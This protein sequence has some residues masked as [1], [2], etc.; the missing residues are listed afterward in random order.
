[1]VSYR[2]MCR[3]VRNIDFPR[4]CACITDGCVGNDT[5][6]QGIS[7]C[8]SLLCIIPFFLPITVALMTV[9]EVI[10]TSEL[11]HKVFVPPPSAVTTPYDPWLMPYYFEDG[12]RRVKPYHFTYNTYCKERWRGR[13]LIDI[14]ATEFRDRPHEYYVS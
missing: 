11:E 2:I 4:G 12:L 8:L 14:F 10:S 6:F 9:Q 5:L 1:M 7:Y 13:E 3:S